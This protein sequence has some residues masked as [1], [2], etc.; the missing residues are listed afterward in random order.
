LKKPVTTPAAP[1]SHGAAGPARGILRTPAASPGPFQHTRTLPSRALAPFVAHYWQVAWSLRRPE[2]AETLPH[3]AVHMVFER[4]GRVRRAEIAGAT[5]RRFVRRLRG[6]GWVFGIKFRPAAFSPLFSPPLAGPVQALT[7]RVVPIQAVL[8]AAGTEL[9]RAIFAAPDVAAR[10]AIAEAALASRLKSLPPALARLR[11]LVERMASD[12]TLL[13]VDDAAAVLAC[14]P[15][16]LQR[17]F[18]A[19]VGVSPKWVIRR[20]RLHEAVERLK[21]PGAPSLA[22]LAADLGYADQAHFARDFKIAVGCTPRQ[23]AAA[24][25]GVRPQGRSVAS[26][27]SK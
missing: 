5:T 20:Y 2:A 16:A 17:R 12:Q 8:G 13:R 21:A 19:H 26:S 10:I 4:R 27:S 9:A 23:F 7:D 24:A 6:E 15:R 11:D 3:P 18:R 25:A 1:A 14:D 22:A